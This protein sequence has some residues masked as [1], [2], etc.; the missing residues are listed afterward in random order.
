MASRLKASRFKA[1][2]L[3]LR[4]SDSLQELLIGA[5]IPVGRINE[6]QLAKRLHVSRT[7]LREALVSLEREGFVMS[8]GRGFAVPPLREREARAIYPIL[9]ALEGLALRSSNNFE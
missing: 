4:V 2:N 1:G 9:G 6:S 8:G 7:P 3:R 5:M